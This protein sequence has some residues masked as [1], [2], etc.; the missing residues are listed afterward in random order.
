M[1]PKLYQKSLGGLTLALGLWMTALQA[2]QPPAPAPQPAPAAQPPA[3]PK[4][5]AAQVDPKTGAVIVPL[6]GVVS[7]KPDTGKDAFSDVVVSREDILQVRVSATDPREL[8][9]TGRTT[10]QVQLTLVFKE[11]PPIVYDVVVQPD[12]ALLRSL[13]RRTVPT[14]NVEVTPGLGNTI[15]LSGY[16]TSPQ[17]AEII[18][19]LA[20]NAA[21]QVPGQAAGGQPNIINA[22]QIGGGQQVQIDVVVASVDRNLL[23][24]RGFD[25]AVSGTTVQIS[26]LVS[27]LIGVQ[28]QQQQNIPG[29]I[30]GVSPNANLQLGIT[31]A[32]FIAGLQAL[33]N[34]GV[35]KFIAEPRVVTQSGR[36]AF[37]RAG[38]QQ[39]IVSPQ[40][41]LVGPGAQLQPFGTEL[42]VLPIVYGNGMI[43]LEIQPRISAVNFGLGIIINGQATPGFTE[44]SVRTAVMLESGQTYAIGG[45]IQNSIEANNSKIPVLGDLPFIGVGFSRLRHEIREQELIILV[46]PRL[47]GPLNCDQVPQRVPGR[48]T[49]EPDD[50]ELFL[51]NILEAPRGQRKV[52]NGRCYNAPYKCD[53]TAAIFPCVGDV[54]TGQGGAMGTGQPSHNGTG[55]VATPAPAPLPP[56]TPPSTTGTPLGSSANPNLSQE[57]GGGTSPQFQG[58][59]SQDPVPTSVS[60]MPPKMEIPEMRRQ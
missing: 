47:V 51:E 31:P 43:W 2:Q 5:P 46:T 18:L 22:M 8:L 41:G 42:E 35:A 32:S 9:L 30:R 58:S 6:G 40:A 21:G 52:W 11:R 48:E 14:A 19:Q 44:Q 3:V 16:V 1:H 4:P 20:A 59:T 36:P 57:A 10:G 24:Q 55:K 60:G 7:F 13:I 26:S 15:I 49:R 27:G 45:L 23:R 25:F 29:R 38:G 28:Q 50:Y 53:P 33:R 17:D 12:L 56:L 39:A 34:E 37:F 54:C